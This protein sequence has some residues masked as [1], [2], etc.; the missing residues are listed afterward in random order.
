MAFGAGR[1]DR[2]VEIQRPVADD[3]FRGAG[4][5]AWAE[6]AKVWANVQDALP[7]RGETASQ[8]PAMMMRPSRVRIRYR[9]D[10]TAA[11]RF[12]MG[13][14]EMYIISGPAEIGRREAL[15]FMVAEYMPGGNPA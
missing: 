6:V 14:R 2:R 9:R 11:M 7:S 1:Y 12:V 3:S 15:E 5:G 13:D 10:V 4:S 8:L